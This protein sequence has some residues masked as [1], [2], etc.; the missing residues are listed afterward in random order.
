MDLSFS[1]IRTLCLYSIVK[2]SVNNFYVIL[3]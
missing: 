1:I 2:K 3:S